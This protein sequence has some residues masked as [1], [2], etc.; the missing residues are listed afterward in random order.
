MDALE[1]NSNDVV[2]EIGAGQGTLTRRLAGRVGRVVAIEKD[3]QLVDRL[4]GRE[5]GS[6]KREA[7]PP[8]PSNV[9]VVGGDALRTDW[10]GLATEP[11][12]PASRFPFPVKI[13]GNIPYAITSPL[14]EKA[15]SPPIPTLVVFLVQREVAERLV[16]DPGNKRYG[17]LTVG[18]AVVAET[19]LLFRVRAGAFRPP[20][21][22][23]SAVVRFRPRAAP[24]VPAEQHRAFRRFVVAL[25]GQRRKQLGTALRGVT[26]RDATSVAAWL[27]GLGLDRRV[28]TEELAPETLVALFEKVGEGWERGGKD[29]EGG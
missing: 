15:L 14:I 18:V 26:G 16:A 27:D 6:G 3:V 2:I 24:L 25:F 10:N 7:F 21:R 17:A 19:E 5:G 20:P 1:P 12:L 22:V 23:G 29:G 4:C 11:T 13:T 9:T 8:L 28:R